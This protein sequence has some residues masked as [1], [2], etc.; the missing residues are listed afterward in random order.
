MTNFESNKKIHIENKEIEKVNSYK[1]LGQ[2]THLKETISNLQGKSGMELP[3]KIQ[4]N[5]SRREDATLPKKISLQPMYPP[6]NDLRLPSMVINKSSDTKTESSTKGNG[7]E[8][9]RNKTQR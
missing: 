8:D 4:R 2:T 7:K 3:R 5:F 1:Y 6:Y 9:A